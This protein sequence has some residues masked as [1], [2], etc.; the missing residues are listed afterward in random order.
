M[1]KRLKSDNK[2]TETIELAITL[3]VILFCMIM[4]IVFLYAFYA[5][6][7]V[8]DS[9]REAARAEALRN[10]LAIERATEAI[11]GGNLQ[12]DRIVEVNVTRNIDS[13][14]VEVQYDQPSMIPG[15]PK[16][17]GSSSWSDNF[18]LKSKSV[19]KRERP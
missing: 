1:L 13:V 14:E 7:I 19:F 12:S 16:L 10:A 18:R 2:G 4:P 5:K 15:L 3:P 8:V 11:E 17:I 9:A 6:I